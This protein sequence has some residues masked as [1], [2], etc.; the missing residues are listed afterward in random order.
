MNER[1]WVGKDWV[2][3][4]QRARGKKSE[5]NKIK[6]IKYNFQYLRRRALLTSREIS[7]R[8]GRG[9]RV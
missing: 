4:K 9:T 3:G 5:Q 2:K 8:S 6:S 1:L 7:H